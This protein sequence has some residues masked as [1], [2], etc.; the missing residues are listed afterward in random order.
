MKK[1]KTVVLLVN[2]ND[3]VGDRTLGID[4]AERLLRMPRN[5]GWKLPKDS[6]Y[7]LGENGLTIKSDKKTTQ[8]AKK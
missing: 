3:K 6:L 1:E 2:D 4:H 8:N 7:T 5:G